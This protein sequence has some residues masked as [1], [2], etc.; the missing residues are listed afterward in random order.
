M[1]SSSNAKFETQKTH[2]GGSHKRVLRRIPVP[3]WWSC[4]CPVL[5]ECEFRTA[6]IVVTVS[7]L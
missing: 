5:L 7:S 2:L 3:C 1:S 4:R 6:L